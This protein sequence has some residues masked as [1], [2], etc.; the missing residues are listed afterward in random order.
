M[1]TYSESAL[2]ENPEFLGDKVECL[3]LPEAC[4]SKRQRH[5]W[6]MLGGIVAVVYKSARAHGFEPVLYLYCDMNDELPEAGQ[7][8]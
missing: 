5:L 3:V 1:N 8:D 4:L 7:S 6:G 2:L